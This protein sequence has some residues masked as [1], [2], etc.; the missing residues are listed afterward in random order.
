VSLTLEARR[1]ENDV[2]WGVLA[3]VLV[4]RYLLRDVVGLCRAPFERRV[5]LVVVVLYVPLLLI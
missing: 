4:L 5:P 3:R 1:E 2:F